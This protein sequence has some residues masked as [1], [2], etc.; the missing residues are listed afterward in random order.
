MLITSWNGRPEIRS[1]RQK[2]HDLAVSNYIGFELPVYDRY[3]I[4]SCLVDSPYLL[5]RASGRKKTCKAIVSFM[6]VVCPPLYNLDFK[7]LS[8]RAC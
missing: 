4:M 6:V 7:V 1:Q 8:E 2:G 3:S 5:E